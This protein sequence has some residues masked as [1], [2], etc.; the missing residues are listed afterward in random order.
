MRLQLQVPVAH[1][2]G[3]RNVSLYINEN[4]MKIFKKTVSFLTL[5]YLINLYQIAANSIYN[6]T[7][8]LQ[9]TH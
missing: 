6:K 7:I 2:N 8:S 3:L 9:Q 1:P 5:C 4:L